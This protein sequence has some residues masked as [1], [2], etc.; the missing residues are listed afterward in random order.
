MKYQSKSSAAYMFRNFFRLAYV[1]IP[2]ALI[3]AFAAYMYKPAMEAELFVTLFRGE[4]TM[5]NYTTRLLDGLTLLRYGRYWWIFVISVLILAFASAILV[6][7]IDRHMRT[8]Q[9]PALPMR[10]AFGIYPYMFLY[11]V[12]AVMSVEVGTLVAVGISCLIR[13]VGNATAIAAIALGLTLALRVLIG[14]LFGILIITFPLK[15]SENYRF[16]RAMSYSARLMFPKKRISWGFALL[17]PALR[18]AVLGTAYVLQPYSLDALVYAVTFMFAVTYIPCLAY[19]QY[20]DDVG[21]ERRDIGAIM[22]G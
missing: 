19:K 20:Y 15:Y 21:G 18:A 22:F 12:C 2:T 14:Y 13:F 5:D 8:G 3:M 1:S 16:N 17:Y 11:V 9:M 7:K 10:R 6:V 4:F